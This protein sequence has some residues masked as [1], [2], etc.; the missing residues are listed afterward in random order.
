MKPSNTQKPHLIITVGIPGAGKSTFAEHFSETFKAPMISFEQLR[1]KVFNMTEFNEEQ[2]EIM[3][4]LTE[5]VLDEALK[6]GRTI[7]YDGPTSRRIERGNISKKAR[8]AG[9]EP[10][11]VWVQTET[12]TAQK[13][14]TKNNPK[15]QNLSTE[16]FD[17]KLK[18]F[19]APHVNEKAIVISGKHTYPSQLKIVLKNLVQPRVPN[20]DKRIVPHTAKRFLVR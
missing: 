9:Y 1:K 5:S 4:Q 13:R 2:N 14:A 17:I 3:N 12:N 15:K 18:K 20:T 8:D 10:L 6:T 7:V 16:Q 11:F 19:S